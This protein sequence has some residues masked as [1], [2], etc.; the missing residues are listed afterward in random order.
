MIELLQGDLLRADAE[1]LVNAVNCVGVM[2]RGIALQFRDAYP[3]NFKKYKAACDARELQP[4]KML[5][6]DRAPREKP[7]YIIN[8]PT[9]IDWRSK[10]RLAYIEQGLAAIVAEI[11]ARNIQSVALP[12]LGCGLGGLKWNDVQPRIEA[13]FAPLPEVRVL[14]FTPSE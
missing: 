14:L 10:S 12:P 7:R 11:Q 9:K 13:A 2:G 8:F 4:G 1:A 6:F 3:E 5:V